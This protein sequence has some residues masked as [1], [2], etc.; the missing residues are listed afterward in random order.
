MGVVRVSCGLLVAAVFASAILVAGCGGSDS[1][2]SATSE[3]T[4]ET[5]SSEGAST[6]TEPS[7]SLP[8]EIRD[9]G[10]VVIGSSIQFPPWVYE[11]DGKVTGFE[12]EIWEAVAE[13]LGIEVEYVDGAFEGLLPGLEAERYDMVSAGYA[14]RRTRGILRLAQLSEDRLDLRGRCRGNPEQIETTA[15]LCGK[16]IAGDISGSSQELYAQELAEKCNE[17]GKQTEFFRSNRRPRDCGGQARPPRCVCPTGS[18]RC[19]FRPGAAHPS[20]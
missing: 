11:E 6:V 17:E 12:P 18:G 8:E 10:V 19:P 16:T 2:S 15:D 5:G 13:E 7:A 3:A 20:N 1:S 9:S 4:A 14:R